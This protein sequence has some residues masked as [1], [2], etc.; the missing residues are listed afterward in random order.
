M[1]LRVLT[2]ALLISTTATTAC[3]SA[4]AASPV[5]PTAVAPETSAANGGA[6]LPFGQS[7][8]WPNGD[9]ITVANARAIPG[10]S[11]SDPAYKRV[12]AVDVTATNA[13]AQPQL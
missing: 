3:S 4:P 5:S 12:I 2:L 11:T 1:R 9:T 10:A 6:M 8:T 7:H 13:G